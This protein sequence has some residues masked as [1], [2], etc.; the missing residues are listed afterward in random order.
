MLAA[1]RAHNRPRRSLVA[2]VAVLSA[3]LSLAVV[4]STTAPANELDDRE[5]RVHREIDQAKK[6]L[7]HSSKALV[8]ATARVKQAEARLEEAER[9]LEASRAELAAAEIVDAQMQSELDA[10]NARLERAQ[11][12]LA[13]G[14]RS[15][16]EQEDVLRNIA[17]ETY[18]AGSP[19]LMGITLVLTSR[20]PSELSTQLN[21]VRNVL[22]R[23]AATLRR[24]EASSVLLELQEERVA[25]ARRDV[26][27]RRADAA[28]TLAKKQRLEVR[29]AVA[30]ARVEQRLEERTVARKEALRTKK[31]DQRR[32]HQLRKERDK[33]AKLIQQREARIRKQKSKA[34][35]ERAKKASQSRNSPMMHPVDTYITSS[36][37]M[38]L[39]PIYRQ[40]RLHDGTDFGAGCGRPVRAAAG[41]RVIGRYYNVGYGN[42]VIIAHG[43]MRG[44]S[45]TT[46][47]NHL[48]RYSTYVGQR[49]RRGE[50]IGFV[51]T[52]GFST[53]C[54]LHF[55]VFRNGRTVNPMNWL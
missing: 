34:A 50:I 18:Q 32:L 37:G 19:G 26:A 24:L 16:R 5:R 23:E 44:V 31:A 17:A 1:I 39:H 13:R 12:A 4:P 29:A 27:E 14:R 11:T 22:D 30:S 25:D 7:R 38:R 28:E 51:G 3:A 35:I 9:E 8:R 52:T 45:V 33:I 15:H 49:V 36:Y 43:Y 46:T 42:R 48:S 55:M 6:H 40:W 2:V 47:Y 54:H 41:G 53:G 10:A 20:D 21:V